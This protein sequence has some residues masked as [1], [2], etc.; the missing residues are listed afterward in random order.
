MRMSPLSHSELFI[1]RIQIIVNVIINTFKKLWRENHTETTFSHFGYRFS[2]NT[3]T[4]WCSS[5]G[6]SD[7]VVY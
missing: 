3:I 5:F 2:L 6:V 4:A 7:P 1:N